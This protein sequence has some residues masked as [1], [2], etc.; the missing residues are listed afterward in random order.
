VLLFI[1]GRNGCLHQRWKE[2]NSFTQMIAE[3]QRETAGKISVNKRERNK[4]L[5]DITE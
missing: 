3:N 1:A 5:A 2:K 4:V